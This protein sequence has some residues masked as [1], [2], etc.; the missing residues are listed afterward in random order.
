[1]FR[2][3][4]NAKMNTGETWGLIGGIAGGLAGLIGGVIGTFS[5]IRN[6]KSSRE[7]SSMIKFSIICWV[8]IGV[9]LGLMWMLPSPYRFF[10][11]I[12]YSILLPWGI[13]TANRNQRR[14]REIELQDK[15]FEASG[16]NTPS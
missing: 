6:T 15:S 10:L 4:K 11:W 13:A 7:R 1:M 12:P 5:S 3:E 8:A 2:N 14:I 16:D 9:F